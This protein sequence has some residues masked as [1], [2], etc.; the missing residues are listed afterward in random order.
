MPVSTPELSAYQVLLRPIKESDLALLRG[1][2]NSDFVR[3][4]MVT[5]S[6]ISE[7][8][9]YAW[10]KKICHD[11]TQMHW[12]IEYRGKPIG[13]TNVKVPVTGETVNTATTLE[14]GLYIGEPKYQ[15]NILAFAPTL[16]L[17]DYCFKYMK[18]DKF[19]A[20][21]KST[22]VAALKY[23]QQLGY[24]ISSRDDFIHL[25]LQKEAYERQTVTLKSFLSRLRKS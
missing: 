10:F 22:N 1:W 13:A 6:L 20:A 18:V 5:T 11:H 9:Q 16:A 3:E 19:R 14:P 15:G 8:Q 2:R 7:E 23:N 21:V 25:C 12:L 17:Y 24:Q 4:K